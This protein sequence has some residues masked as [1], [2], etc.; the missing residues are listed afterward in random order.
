VGRSSLLKYKIFINQALIFK[1]GTLWVHIQHCNEDYSTQ[2]EAVQCIYNLLYCMDGCAKNREFVDAFLF[3]CMGFAF[4]LTKIKVGRVQTL[5]LVG[6]ILILL[7][8][9]FGLSHTESVRK[10]SQNQKKVALSPSLSPIQLTE[11]QGRRS[12]LLPARTRSLPPPA[13]FWPSDALGFGHAMASVSTNRL[14]GTSTLLVKHATM[15]SDSTSI[16]VL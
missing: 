7:A 1:E 3:R 9:P 14:P 13:A 2:D 15:T 6:P 10:P 8:H 16:C 4:G 12:V 11:A 5:N